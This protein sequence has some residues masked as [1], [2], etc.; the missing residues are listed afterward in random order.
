VIQFVLS[1]WPGPS[2]RVPDPYA[3]TPEVD[4]TDLGCRLRLSYGVDDCTAAVAEVPL[5]AVLQ[6][7]APV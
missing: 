3:T 4:P 5:Q 6:G 1:V 7:L 2:C